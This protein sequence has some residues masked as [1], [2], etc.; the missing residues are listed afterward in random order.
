M[1]KWPQE[2]GLSA[3]T[4]E[5][6]ENGALRH[7]DEILFCQK[8]PDGQNEIRSSAIYRWSGFHISTTHPL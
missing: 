3:C 5:N 7:F 8:K 6:V 1:S 4:V 2:Q